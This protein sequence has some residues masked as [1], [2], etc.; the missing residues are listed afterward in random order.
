V[1]GNDE[2]YSYLRGARETLVWKME[3]LG[4]YDI[5]RPMTPT[6]TNLLGLVKHSARSHLLY[7]CDA[8]DRPRDQSLR[9]L[10]EV[11]RGSDMWA[12]HD[13]SADDIVKA[14][15]RSWEL[16]DETVSALPIDAL[17]RVPW[18]GDDPVT[19][20]R[21]VVHVTAETQRHAGHADIIRELIDGSVGLLDGFDNLHSGAPAVWSS[22]HDQIDRA[23]QA[24][25]RE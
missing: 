6:G 1:D 20:E 4:E 9:W 11:A 7:F 14:Y 24:A 10:A 25:E 3:G 2:L 21:V 8:F 19:L 16:A 12:K 18:W 5:R 17:G 22:L 15:R 13:E 23:A